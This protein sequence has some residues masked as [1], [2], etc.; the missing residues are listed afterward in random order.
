MQFKKLFRY[1][2]MI[3]VVSTTFVSCNNDDYKTGADDVADTVEDG[4]WKVGFFYESGLAQTEDYG[5]Y[6]FT[7]TNNT[8][9]TATKDTNTNTGAW[10][11]A[12]ST[13]DADISGTLFMI[14][15][16]SPDLIKLSGNWKVI[17]N[18]GTSLKL[19]D[20]S[21]GD[22]DERLLYFEKN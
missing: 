8:V 19:K 9:L 5:G 10:S 1:V 17:E 14:L 20:N 15:F 7:F 3:V 21:K 11:V 2:L 18:T 4:T 22:T 16:A 12:K 6:N 13:S